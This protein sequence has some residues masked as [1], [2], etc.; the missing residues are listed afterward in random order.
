MPG[1]GSP[2]HATTTA[3]R[4]SRPARGA[5]RSTAWATCMAS[6]VPRSCCFRG[7][8]PAG[9]RPSRSPTSPSWWRWTASFAGSGLYLN[10]D[11][12]VAE[13]DDETFDQLTAYCEGVNDGMKDSGRSLPMWATGFVPQPWNQKSVLL[14]GNLLSFGG[15]AVGQQQNERM[16]LDL[17]QA[18]VADDK[19]RELF[20][21]LLDDADFRPAAAGQDRQPAFGRSPGADHRLA[22]PGRQQRLGRR[23][24]AQRH[25]RRP[26]G[27]RPAPGSQSPAGHLVRGGAALG[28]HTTCWAP[29]CRAARCLPWPARATVLGRDVSERGHERLLH[30]RLPRSPEPALAVS[31]RRRSGTISDVREEAI[32]RKGGTPEVLH[33]PVQRPR[34]RWKTNPTEAS[35]ATTCR[36]PGSA[37]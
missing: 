24:P 3:C 19:L 12:E 6:T 4:T 37:T 9:S 31:P 26:A 15:L 22:A 5:L 23:P 33:D 2:S 21:P 17:I 18:G 28:R 29:R 16:L 7:P 8:W 10:L 1:G 13:L 25:R 34:A 14:M 30:R 20:S 36:T 35:R 11:Q 27:L 32:V